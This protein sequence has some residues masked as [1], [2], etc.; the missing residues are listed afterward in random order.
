MKKPIIISMLC[1]LSMVTCTKRE[2]TSDTLAEIHSEVP[3][4]ADTSHLRVCR[5]KIKGAY[6]VFVTKKIDATKKFYQQWFAYEILFESSWFIL[7]ASPG[8]QPSLLA[9]IDEEHPSSPPSPGVFRGEGAFYT[10]DV[11]DAAVLYAAMK[12]AGVAFTHHLKDEPWGQRRFAMAD[13]NGV[14]IDVVEQIQPQP[15]WWDKYIL[16]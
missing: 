2:K 13:P 6:P 12:T 9:F 1:G 15:G 10:M 5:E 4:P 3:L 7:L 16:K 8:E 11:S 14:W